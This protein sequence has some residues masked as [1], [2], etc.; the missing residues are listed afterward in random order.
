M[1]VVMAHLDQC[2]AATD[3]RRLTLGLDLAPNALHE[4][5]EYTLAIPQFGLGPKRLGMGDLDGQV[6]LFRFEHVQ[7]QFHF[8]SSEFEIV[9]HDVTRPFQFELFTGYASREALP[10]QP[11]HSVFEESFT[12][13]LRTIQPYGFFGAA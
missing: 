6:A 2:R 11:L 4:P 10:E 9:N 13:G 7:Q 8:L 5:I 1:V 3:L 12:I